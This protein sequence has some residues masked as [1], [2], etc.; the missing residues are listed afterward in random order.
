MTITPRYLQANDKV[1]IVSTARKITMEE[2]TPAIN[3]FKSWNLDVVVGDT[4]GLEYNQEA[5]TDKQ[6][7]QDLQRFLDDDT[8]KAIFC[9]RGGY[10]T[11]RIL[12][13]IN[14][15][16]FIYCPKWIVGYS[17]VTALLSH[18]YFNYN[19][20]AIHG[21]MPIN[22]TDNKDNVAVNSLKDILFNNK[23]EII[24][25]ANS[26][27]RK[28]RSSGEII[29]GNLSV[30][31]SLMGSNSFVDTDGKILFIEDLDEYLYHIDRMM[32]AL[33]RAGK[34]SNLKGLIV[35]Q[36]SDMHDNTI[37]FG[38]TAEEIVFDAVKDYDY[39]VCFNA[40]I[41]HIGEN[42]HAIVYGRETIIDVSCEKVI[43]S[44]K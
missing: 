12:N 41:G 3:L 30:L 38:K 42:N 40:P 1:A 26:L 23:N 22:I 14:F 29:G 11:V 18:L 20:E 34:L 43:V 6:R 10:G 37:S 16:D 2:I 21:I 28:G 8:I 24:F 35:G 27:N 7:A 39:P 17:D 32:M 5:G 44:Q 31:Y 25:N 19:I 36:M 33:K 9:A 4:I 13:L 15:N